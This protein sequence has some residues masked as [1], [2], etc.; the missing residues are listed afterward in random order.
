VIAAQKPTAKK[1]VAQAPASVPAGQ[2][3]AERQPDRGPVPSWVKLT[4][5]PDPDPKKAELPFQAL[6]LDGQTL[7]DPSGVSTYFEMVLRPQTVAGLQGFS[8]ITLPWSVSQADLVIHAIEILRDGKSIDLI[9]NNPFTIIRREAGLEKSQIDGLRTVVLPAKGVELGDNIRISATY[10]QSD[11]SLR[12]KAEDLSGWFP[13]FAVGQMNRRV[14][15]PADLNVKW[16]ISGR[17]PKPAISKTAVGTEYH[18]TASKMEPETFPRFML[19]ADKADDIQFSAYENWAEAAAAHLPLYDEARKL[20]AGSSLS[21]EADK[22]AASSSDPLKRMMAALRLA[23]ERVRYVALL[24]GEGAYKPTAAEAAWEARYGDCKA[25]TAL[26]L[27]LLDRLGIEASPMYVS[28]SNGGKL[29]DRLPSLEPFDHVIV[30]AK[31]GNQTYY[32]DATDYGHRVPKDVTGSTLGY[33]LPLIANAGLEKIPQYIP[34][35]P[36]VETNVVWNGSKDL[37]GGVPFEAKAIL[38]GP[39]A[40]LARQKKAA[41]EKPEDFEVFLKD[42]VK[43]IENDVIKIT[44]QVDDAASGDYTISFAGEASLGWDEYESLKGYRFVFDND[45]SNW[46][47]DFERSEGPFKDAVVELNPSYW[48]RETEVLI[49]PSEK[50]FK[51]DAA[52]IDQ[53]IAGTRIW[54]TVQMANNRVTAVT[55]FRHMEETISAEQAR[56]AE[57]GLK[58]IAESWA[59]VIGPRKLVAPDKD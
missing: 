59:Y 36:I 56:S 26:L 48:Q 10:R 17:I 15:V 25:K 1:A 37:K 27:A 12:P 29:K 52:P 43:G 2:D 16:R 28:S 40:I 23:Q 47:A 38:R 21:A 44:G 31:V 13:P 54:R 11:L 30:R 6:L 41:A 24:L 45:A 49:L 5:I 58:S 3:A 51:V 46:E 22:L 35:Q 9:G 57:A 55:N 20:T 32:L 19:D 8:T 50:G 34:D 7:M 39:S 4:K 18:F 14:V 33:G 42:Y 53:T